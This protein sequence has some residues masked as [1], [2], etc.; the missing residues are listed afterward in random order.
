MSLALAFALFLSGQSAAEPQK[1]PPEPAPAAQAPADAK[2]AAEEAPWPS[3]VPHDDYL[4]VSWCYGALRGYVDLHDQVMPEVTRIE[5][6]F[7]EPGRTLAEDLKVYEDELRQARTDLKTFQAAITAAE[8]ASLKPINELGGKQVEKGHAIWIP[9]GGGVSKAQLAQAWMS[10]TL[11]ARCET[12]APALLQRAKLMGATFKVN[13]QAVAEAEAKPAETPAQA[14][15]LK[16]YAPVE[17]RTADVPP[18]PAPAPA[19]AAEAAPA[20]TKPAPAVCT[21]SQI[22][23]SRT[24]FGG[25][26]PLDCTMPAK[27]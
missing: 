17:T 23:K 20:E 15:D 6:S 21:A 10:W 24:L 27:P 25:N 22:R 14:V 18:P 1:G 7:R 4:L 16:P 8:K 12:T 5:S 26:K 9:T 3:G 2:P 13:E 11:P 19:P